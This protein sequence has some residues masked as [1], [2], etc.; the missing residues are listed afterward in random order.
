MDVN[1]GAYKLF[2]VAEKISITLALIGALLLALK[3]SQML[4]LDV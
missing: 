1:N 2:L 4:D 3:V